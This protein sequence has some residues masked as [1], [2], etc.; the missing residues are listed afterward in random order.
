MSVKLSG[1]PEAIE[2]LKTMH[3]KNPGF[4]KAVLDDARS[5]TDHATS[6]RSEAGIRYRVTLDPRTGDLHLEEM[7]QT[8]KPPPVE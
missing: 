3:Q 1:D 6:F 8:S 4:V 5:T 2:A 7:A